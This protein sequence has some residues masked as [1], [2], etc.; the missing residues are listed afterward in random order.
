MLYVTNS[1][2]GGVVLFLY[3]WW[4]TRIKIRAVKMGGYR[5]SSLFYVIMNQ[6]EAEVNYNAKIE[7][8]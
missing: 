1:F 5:P 3:D 8:G 2:F 7:R 4:M 6:D